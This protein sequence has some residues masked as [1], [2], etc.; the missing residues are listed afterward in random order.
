MNLPNLA[1]QKSISLYVSQIA[2]LPEYRILLGLRS[3]SEVVQK[4][5]DEFF[6]RHAG[7]LAPK[8]PTA[9]PNHI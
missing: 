7:D 3:D 5:L 6:E 2:R 8:K 9:D 1:V 4:A